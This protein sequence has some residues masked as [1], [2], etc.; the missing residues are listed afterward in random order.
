M[1]ISFTGHRPDKLGVPY[2]PDRNN[3]LYQ[4]LFRMLQ[5]L[6]S[7]WPDVVF[8]TGAAVGFDQNIAEIGLE[9]GVSQI[10]ARPCP[11]QDAKWPFSTR[12]YYQN[13]LDA[14]SQTGSVIDTSDGPYQPWMMQYRN[15]WMVDHCD[16]VFSL[17]DGSPGGTRNCI[18]YALGRRPI[19]NLL[20]LRVIS[21][22]EINCDR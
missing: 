8:I 3:R 7:L 6:P 19:I 9:L 13:L 2:V 22:L 1:R 4:H 21:S 20:P 17:W 12:V 15:R 5:P 18:Q 16:V 11:N 14:V 10:I